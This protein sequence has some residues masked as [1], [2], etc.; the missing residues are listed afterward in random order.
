MDISGIFLKSGLTPIA[1]PILPNGESPQ[2]VFWPIP[3]EGT[4]LRATARW[5][6]GWL[7]YFGAVLGK[8]EAEC[9]PQQRARCTSGKHDQLRFE[10]PLFSKAGIRPRSAQC[11]LCAKRGH[12]P[13][14]PPHFGLGGLETRGSGPKRRNSRFASRTANMRRC[15]I[16]PTTRIENTTAAVERPQISA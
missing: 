16:T 15:R 5:P 6:L 12:R 11:P 2:P 14:R 13:L 1:T 10:C 3:F 4:P 7:G 8:P 9:P